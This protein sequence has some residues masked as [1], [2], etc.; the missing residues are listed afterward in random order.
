M[1]LKINVIVEFGLYFLEFKIVFLFCFFYAHVQ[2]SLNTLEK[3]LSLFHHPKT[4]SV[5][6]SNTVRLNQFSLVHKRRGCYHQRYVG[7]EYVRV[8]LVLPDLEWHHIFDIG[9]G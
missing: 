8:F 2:V 6:A 1:S 4:S 9:K 3:F 5:L 7:R